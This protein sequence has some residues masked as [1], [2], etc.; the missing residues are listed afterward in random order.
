MSSTVPVH[1]AKSTFRLPFVAWASVVLAA[2]SLGRALAS[3][4]TDVANKLNFSTDVVYQIVTDRFI[5]GNSANNPTGAA[6][7][8]GCVQLKLYCG[9]GWK[10]IQKKNKKGY[11]AGLGVSGGWV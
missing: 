9:G 10:R 4:D 5:D 11:P 3:P 8:S 2:C 7:S 1:T 6:F